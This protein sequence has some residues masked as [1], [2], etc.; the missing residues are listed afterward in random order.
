MKLD[1]KKVRRDLQCLFGRHVWI[2]TI[3]APAYLAGF[4][5]RACVH[6]PATQVYASELGRWIDTKK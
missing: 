1:W 2:R 5:T 6:C 3:S 4:N